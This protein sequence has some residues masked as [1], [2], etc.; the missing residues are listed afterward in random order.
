MT[1]D[2]FFIVTVSLTI[3]GFIVYTLRHWLKPRNKGEGL[4]EFAQ[5]IDADR[6]AYR[7][8]KG[9]LTNSRIKRANSL[10]SNAMLIGLMW[11]IAHAPNA[12]WIALGYVAVGTALATS[13]LARPTGWAI[14][15]FLDRLLWR[16]EHAWFWPLLVIRKF[17]KL[18]EV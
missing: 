12:R 7:E 10:F 15:T 8:A 3:A 4:A 16:I 14:L 13:L 18:N 6:Q 5:R 2:Q 1:Y 9:E 17:R 11:L